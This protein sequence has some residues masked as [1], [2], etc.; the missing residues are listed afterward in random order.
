[1]H[2]ILK[3]WRGKTDATITE[4][5]S[6]KFNKQTSETVNKCSARSHEVMDTFDRYIEAND[7]GHLSAK[8]DHAVQLLEKMDARQSVHAVSLDRLD[9][10]CDSIL[11]DIRRGD[12]RVVHTGMISQI[13]E[14]LQAT[15]DTKQLAIHIAEKI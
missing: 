8:L 14:V 2:Q 6:L 3:T 9:G 4:R 13:R 5:E 12:H 15:N 10:V 11:D 7:L 1:M